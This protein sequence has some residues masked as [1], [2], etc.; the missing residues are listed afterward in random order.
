MIIVLFTLSSKANDE[1]DPSIV[2][3]QGSGNLLFTLPSR[4]Y[5]VTINPSKDKYDSTLIH[6][7]NYDRIEYVS[8]PQACIFTTLLGHF[9]QGI[10]SGRECNANTE[11]CGTY[12]PG[13]WEIRGVSGGSCE[14][15]D[16]RRC[17]SG[18]C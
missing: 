18:I 16:I 14:Q 1:P 10:D 6:R 7:G 13:N 9:E 4:W 12:V 17:S 5:H 3:W 2:R 15:F 11:S 8:G